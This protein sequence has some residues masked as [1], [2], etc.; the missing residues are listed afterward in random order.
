MITGG[1]QNPLAGIYGTA[2]DHVVAFQVVTAVDRFITTS[3]VANADLFWALHGGGGGTCAVA[4]S[5]I[6][7]VHPKLS[8][9]TSKWVLDASRNGVEAF[10]KGTNKFFDIFVDWVDQGI[11]SFFVIGNAPSPFLNMM[12][13]FAS[14]HITESYTKVVEPFFDHLNFNNTTLTSSYSS[15]AHTSFYPDGV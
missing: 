2:A 1:G 15:L 13:L 6:I 5:V 10:W 12:F 8:V 11:Y 9:V 4:T 7:R 14:N 3:K